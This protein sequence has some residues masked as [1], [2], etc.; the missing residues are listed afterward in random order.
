MMIALCGSHIYSPTSSSQKL[1]TIRLFGEIAKDVAKANCRLES[2]FVGD[3]AVDGSDIIWDGVFATSAGLAYLNE[4]GPSNGGY[5]YRDLRKH[6]LSLFG[7]ASNK[8][9]TAAA[10]REKSKQLSQTAHRIPLTPDDLKMALQGGFR[11][12][13]ITL[14]KRRVALDIRS[15]PKAISIQRSTRDRDTARHLLSTGDSLDMKHLDINEDSENPDCAICWTEA[16]DPHRT[17]CGHYYCQGCFAD[18]CS[19]ADEGDLPIRCL[20]DAGSCLQTLSIEELRATLSFDA[21][22]KLLLDSVTAH[23]RTNPAMYQYCPTPDCQIA[24]RTST[25]GIIFTCADC[26]TPICTTCQTT[27][28]DG[29]TCETYKR[30]ALEGDEDFKRWKAENDVKDC[31]VCKV[32]IEKSYGCNHMECRNCKTHIC[33]VCLKTFTSGSDCYGHMQKVHGSFM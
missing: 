3:T 28:H 33:W 25:T 6:R 32:P 17:S 5:I 29:M 7:S 11:R 16:V 31:P 8:E 20:G 27:S 10:L 24:Y 9:K 21:F 15:E 22:E 1:I 4:L 19:A 2:L 30:T 12:I 26:L 18:Q 23:I 14:E 13:V